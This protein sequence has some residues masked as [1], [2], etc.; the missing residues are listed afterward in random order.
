MYSYCY[1]VNL[2][3]RSTG[4]TATAFCISCLLSLPLLFRFRVRFS[5]GGTFFFFFFSNVI[6]HLHFRDTHLTFH[7]Q[8][9]T[10]HT[11]ID[12]IK[13][14]LIHIHLFQLKR[15]KVTYVTMVPRRERDT[16]LNDLGTTWR[17]HVLKH[18]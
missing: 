1:V 2:L 18:V 3:N 13:H 14:S 6:E 15:L 8:T 10:I 4:T 9:T 5:V 12:V 17:D 16:V 7:S 11:T